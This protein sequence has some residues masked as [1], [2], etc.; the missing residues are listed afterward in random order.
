M[1]AN[2][3]ELVRLRSTSSPDVFISCAN[4]EKMGNPADIAYG[5]CVQALSVQA[6][7][8][9]IESQPSLGS[10]PIYSMLGNY[11]GPT[12]A[13]RKVKLTVSSIR[14]TR[15]FATR[16]VLANQKLDDGSE[17]S[18]FCATIDFVAPT[19][20]DAA[21]AGEPF[22]TYG[23]KP[24]MQ[25]A[26]PEQLPSMRDIVLRK[27]QEGKV[28]KAA[29][30]YIE[31]TVFALNKKALISAFPPQGLHAQN[32]FGLDPLAES[33][34]HALPL[35]DRFAV[36]W[37]KSLTHLSP[38][39]H[40]P[41]PASSLPPSNYN[42]ARD[43]LSVSK[44]SANASLLAFMMDGALSF[45]PLTFSK[46]SLADAAAVSSLDTAL[47]FF[48]VPNMD[49]FHLREMQTIGGGDCRTYSEAFLWDRQ[50]GL[51]ACATQACVLRPHKHKL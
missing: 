6:A 3:I 49:E 25:Y 40:P 48:K 19:N 38:P 4:P 5:G 11:L 44:A 14:S 28:N 26:P 7:F 8:K 41:P 30:D 17:R 45:I 39:S 22:T 31:N 36:D 47:R 29:A 20:V 42:E 16:F 13:D 9:S 27:V 12:S 2:F 46:L 10:F 15:S 33:D 23:K 21:K 43:A 1:A 34:Q 24:R 18:T 35:T 37:A 51:V 32:A 50:G